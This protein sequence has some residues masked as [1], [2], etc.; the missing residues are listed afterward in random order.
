MKDKL[1]V[2]MYVRTKH[3]GI[4][5]ILNI[6]KVGKTIFFKKAQGIDVEVANKNNPIEDEII[7]SDTNIIDLIEVGDILLLFDKSYGENYKAEVLL[8]SIDCKSIINYEQCD[9]LNL[10][11]EL[12]TEEHIKLL[13]ILTKVQFVSMSYKVG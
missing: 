2:G 9:L 8:D 6:E 5:K 1:E 13:N 4:F 7:K 12:I 3:Y 11:Y 10:E